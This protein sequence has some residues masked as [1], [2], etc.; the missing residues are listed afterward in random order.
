MKFQK[1]AAFV[2]ALCLMGSLIG[3]TSTFS[4]PTG[5]LS[6][7]A[8]ASTKLTFGDLTYEVVEDHVEITG[9]KA[10]AEAVEIPS[11]IDGKPV[12]VIGSAAF[13]G[14]KLTS[15]VIPDSVTTIAGGAFWKSAA[16]TSVVIPESVTS[17]ANNAFTDCTALA[18]I[19]IPASV[20]SFGPSAFTGTAWLAAQQ[21][22]NPFVVVNGIVIDA[23]KVIDNINAQR[24]AEAEAGEN[25]D[26][27]IIRTEDHPEAE[28]FEIK[29]P[30]N[31]GIT[32]IGE[33]VFSDLKHAIYVT[34]IV[35]PEG[36]TT[37]CKEAFTLC[38][39]CTNIELPSTLLEI[40]DDA[41]A[42][43]LW[44]DAQPRTD[45]MF[46]LGNLLIDGSQASG[47]V[48]IPSGV[49]TVCGNAFKANEAITSVSFPETVTVI[50]D[51]AFKCCP[52]LKAIQLP[53][54][55]KTIGKN[56]FLECGLVGLVIP[57][58]VELVDDAAFMTCKDLQSVTVQSDT[59]RI[60]ENA[61]GCINV[62]TPTGQYAHIYVLEVNH[63]FILNCR[64]GSTAEAYAKAN[65]MV[66][67]K[68]TQGD[69]NEDLTVNISDVILLSRYVSEDTAVSIT[70]AGLVNAECTGDTVLD[71]ADISKL[72]KMIAR[73]DE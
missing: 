46:V 60:G 33:N 63:D 68:V 9:C 45:G 62:F 55:L 41:L 58:G 52:A 8:A 43:T 13:Y 32:T 53:E 20:T 54:S 71:S 19:S 12:T 72:M 25:A 6:A 5:T 22:E 61:F 2:T 1:T 26:T 73:V 59:V 24:A 36:V 31:M 30:A 23:S 18:D 27:I 7:A 37:L 11:E 28:K 4:A 47:N 64:E 21:E 40:G 56:A 51:S 50:G 44:I 39:E 49:T 10:D 65:D 66:T 67:Q 29:F 42:K 69:V 35:V 57:A 16:L 38:H 15:V 48:C 34:S 14:S 17:I 3:T 70:E